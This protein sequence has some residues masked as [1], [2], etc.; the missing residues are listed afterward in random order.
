MDPALPKA[1]A[2]EWSSRPFGEVKREPATRTEWDSGCISQA[3]SPSAMA[4]A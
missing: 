1:I 4:C 3:T 2:S